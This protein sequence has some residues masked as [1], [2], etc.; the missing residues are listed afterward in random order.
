[1]K[2]TRETKPWQLALLTMDSAPRDGT[3]FIHVTVITVLEVGKPLR[4]VAHAE[5]M[6]RT[7]CGQP[8]I[9]PGFWTTSAGSVPDA[10]ANSGYWIPS[11]GVEAIKL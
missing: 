10:S 4:H 3:K 2:P 8:R 11:W 1:M 6:W 5:E 7:W 9:G